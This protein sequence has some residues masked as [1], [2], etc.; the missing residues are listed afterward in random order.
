MYEYNFHIDVKQ[1]HEIFSEKL[2]QRID[3][4]E[5]Q[6]TR[7][8][9]T[10]PST[11]NQYFYNHLIAHLSEANRIAEAKSMML[12]LSWLLSSIDHRPRGVVDVDGDFK[13]LKKADTGNTLSSDIDRDFTLTR[14][15][16][17][18]SLSQLSS[19][20]EKSVFVLHLIG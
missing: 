4:Y 15:A 19:L 16:I 14:Q 13:L 5:G 7:S 11:I 12:R 8:T 1:G 20:Q 3:G 2:L 9:M 6:S 18:M 10:F 17:G